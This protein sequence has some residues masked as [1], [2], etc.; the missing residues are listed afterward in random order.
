VICGVETNGFERAI[1]SGS[2]HHGDALAA[3]ELDEGELAVGDLGCNPRE[4]FVNAVTWGASIFQI[5]NVTGPML[6]GFLFTVSFA[7]KLNGAPL[8]YSFTLASLMV[9][10]T[11]FTMIRPRGA[12]EKKAFTVKTVLAGLRYVAQTRFPRFIERDTCRDVGGVP[13]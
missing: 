13:A 2:K 11:L 10:L 9:Y 6:G 12:A 4:H 1:E 3:S 5:A 7:G 8:V